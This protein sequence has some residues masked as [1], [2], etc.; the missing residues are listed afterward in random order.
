MNTLLET[1]TF[2]KIYTS[3]ERTEQIWINKIKDKLRENLKV[4]KPLHFSWFR[5]KKL[6]N[7]R[8][9]YVINEP[10]KTAILLA[11]GSKKDQQEI[12]DHILANKEKYLALVNKPS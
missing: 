2:S 9:F 3:C 4:G 10:K 6:G 7:K 5:E 11:F 1:E 12:I 8:L